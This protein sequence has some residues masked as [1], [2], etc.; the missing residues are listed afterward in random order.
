MI[1]YKPKVNEL[2]KYYNHIKVRSHLK[3]YNKIQ[4]LILSNYF[5]ELLI[6]SIP[7]EQ[8][9]LSKELKNYK[10]EGINCLYLM[11]ALER[12]NQNYKDKNGFN[13]FLNKEA[14]PLGCTDREKLCLMLGGDFGFK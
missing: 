6:Y 2:I 9:T 3:E 11:G 13:R 12:D 8:K 7:F 5:R 1:F 4:N 14:P 10:E